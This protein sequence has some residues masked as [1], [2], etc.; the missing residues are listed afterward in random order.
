M[1][2]PKRPTVSILTTTVSSVE[3]ARRLAR[4][5]VQRRL[6]AC[7]QLEQIESHYV[8]Q[9]KLCDEPEWRVV[10]KTTQGSLPALVD[11]LKGAHPY[12]LPQM[13]MRE[14]GASPDY[15]AWVGAGCAA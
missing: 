9:S 4:E 1:S 3:D 2:E 12:E 13:L 11:W 15:A 7:A 6:A 5:V 10:F 8:W 14:E